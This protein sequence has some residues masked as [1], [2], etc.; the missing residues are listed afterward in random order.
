MRNK[1]KTTKN[2][3]FNKS[4][5]VYGLAVNR[6][7]NDTKDLLNKEI[8]F[9]DIIKKFWND[10]N[11]NDIEVIW[12]IFNLGMARARKDLFDQQSDLLGQLKQKFG[13]ALPL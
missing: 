7:E 10:K 3:D 5:G 12:I 13:G 11:Y 2:N 9:S 1:I 6:L 4:I 8:P